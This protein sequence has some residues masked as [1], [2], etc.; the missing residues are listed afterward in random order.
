MYARAYAKWIGVIVLLVG[1]VGLIM[2]DPEDGLLGFNVDVTE[3]IVHLATGGLLAYAGF[4]GTDD[5]ARS[6]V[7]VI[8]VVYL[9]VGIIGFSSKTC[10]VFCRTS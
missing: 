3:D 8:G 2:G 9:L 1:V 5:Q 4:S 6:I 10:S 7:T